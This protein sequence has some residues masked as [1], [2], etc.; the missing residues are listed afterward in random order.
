MQFLQRQSLLGR[1]LLER[2]FQVQSLL[3]LILRWQIL[4]MLTLLEWISLGQIWLEQL[5]LNPFWM[6]RSFLIAESYGISAWKLK[7]LQT[8]KQSNL[9]ITYWGIPV[10]TV[11]NL[12]VAQFIYLL[13][14]SEKIRD[15][16]TVDNVY[17]RTGFLF[18]RIARFY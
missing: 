13:L 2:F 11:D 15:V 14:H 16:I 5:C 8:A 3:K 17:K 7:G 1:S 10:V 6:K 9:I 4:A 18:K 12:E